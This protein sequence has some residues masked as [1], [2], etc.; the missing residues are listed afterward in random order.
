[1][2]QRILT[3]MRPSGKLHLGHWGGALEQWVELQNSNQY[4]CFWL[5]ADYQVLSDHIID[6]NVIR[7]SVIDVAI[8]WLAAG[9]DP[10]GTSF[11]VQSYIPE[12]AELAM[13]MS[14]IMKVNELER[15]PTLKEELKERSRD[16]L[17]VGFYAY[18]VSQIADILLPRAHLVPVGQ[19]QVPHI[20][21][22]RLAARRF[23]NIYGEVFPEPHA[24]VGRVARL[25]GIDGDAKMSKH[26]G[27][28][29]YL[30]DD[31]KTVAKK[32]MNMFTDPLKKTV[33]DP[34][35]LEHSLATDGVVRMKPHVPFHYLDYFDPD[36]DDL[37][38]F[39]ERYVKG[40]VGDTEVKQRLIKLLNTFLAP[41]RARRV[42]YEAHPTLVV[43]ALVSGTAR[44]KTIAQQT[45]EE[46]REAMRITRYGE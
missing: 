4:D 38:D 39:K 33:A 5:I 3:G 37:K 32:V 8:D 25:V 18:P 40:G 9:L 29:I 2:K 13:L 1:M 35:H 7:Q 6:P 16:Q 21:F 15:N 45:M 43:E 10:E 42:Y 28:A 26:L 11:V 27:N 34:G 23:N 19:D 12:H 20:E 46:V 36:Q 41:I 30:S 14:F 44:A 22:A 31:P 17:T 24:K